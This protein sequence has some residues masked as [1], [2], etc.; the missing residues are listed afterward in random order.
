MRSVTPRAPRAQRRNDAAAGTPRRGTAYWIT[1][2]FLLLVLVVGID[3]ARDQRVTHHVLRAELR[4]GDAAHLR[5]DA[6]C[7]DQPAFLAALQVDLRDVA[8]H[9][10]AGTE[11]DARE[12]HLHLLGRGVLRLVEDDE[13]VIERAPA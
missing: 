8:V 10:R 4:E 11:A 1:R 9:H 6:P 3:D 2:L 13:G 5:E 12:E 7:L